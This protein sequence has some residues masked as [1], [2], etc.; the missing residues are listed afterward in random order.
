[1]TTRTIVILLLFVILTWG[2][3]A[4]IAYGVV[5]LTGGGPQ[6]EQGEQGPRGAPGKRGTRGLTGAAGTSPSDVLVPFEG[7]IHPSVGLEILARF[8]A[9]EAISQLLGENVTT[10]HPQ[11]EDCVSYITEVEGL[12]NNSAADCGFFGVDE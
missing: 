4:A 8:W 11:V 7:N 6:G 2:G 3:S 9:T 5:E 10:M 12:F 1:M